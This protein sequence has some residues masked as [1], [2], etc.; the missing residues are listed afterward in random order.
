MRKQLEKVKEFM[1][2]VNNNYVAEA[3]SEAGCPDLES[4]H[5]PVDQLAVRH[6]G[7]QGIPTG[8]LLCPLH[9]FVASLC[10]YR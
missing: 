3:G 9:Y 6:P 7:V 5:S 8:T 2:K 1:S 10:L 4:S